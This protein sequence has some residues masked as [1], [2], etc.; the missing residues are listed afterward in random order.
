MSE[1]RARKNVELVSRAILDAAKRFRERAA[2][3]LADGRITQAQFEECV[4]TV[5]E[6]AKAAA[7]WWISGEGPPP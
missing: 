2:A 7:S 6:K 3:A 1:N 4:K 5:D